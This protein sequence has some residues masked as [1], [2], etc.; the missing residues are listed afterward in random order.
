MITISKA[1]TVLLLSLFSGVVCVQAGDAEDEFSAVEIKTIKLGGNIGVSSGEDGVFMI[2][3]QFAPLTVR[4]KAAIE[5]ISDKP[6]RFI[7]NTHWHYDH[8]GGNENHG[9][10][11]VVIVAHDNVR[12]RLS[13]DGFIEA[14]NK[15]IPASPKAALPVITFNDRVTF[16]LNQQEIQVI[17]RSNAH[18]DGDSIVIF[19][20]ANVIHTGDTFFNT[21][22]PFIDGSSGGSVKGVIDATDYVLSLANETTK[23]IPGH[24]PLADLSGK[25]IR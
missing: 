16:H 18:T 25:N 10:E 5:K 3:D 9:N 14:F 24:G 8:T 20:S 7:I 19:K 23:I 17:H 11:D 13:K 15:K 2:D 12:E 1:I 4:I 6:I 21:M 22:Y